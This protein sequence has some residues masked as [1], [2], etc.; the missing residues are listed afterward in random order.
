ML[1]QVLNVVP[2]G[3]IQG[4]YVDILVDETT[5]LIDFMDSIEAGWSVFTK[6]ITNQQEIRINPL[7]LLSQNFQPGQ[8]MDVGAV[9]LTVASVVNMRASIDIKI[10][11]M[12]SMTGISGSAQLDL[13][14]KYFKIM[15][16]KVT[17][18][19]DNSSVTLELQPA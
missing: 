3:L 9:H 8:K 10:D 5:G 13:S 12:A 19:Y 6:T 18:E 15:N 4:G 2:Q 14:D 16:V 17:G 1:K 11:D 7:M